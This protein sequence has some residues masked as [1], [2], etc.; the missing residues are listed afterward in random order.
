MIRSKYFITLLFLLFVFGSCVVSFGMLEYENLDNYDNDDDLINIKLDDP[1]GNVNSNKKIINLGTTSAKCMKNKF[2]YLIQSYSF[3]INKENYTRIDNDK[4][5]K[6]MNQPRNN[7][8]DNSSQKAGEVINNQEIKHY[9]KQVISKYEEKIS[10][11]NVAISKYEK[12]I[13]QLESNLLTGY[14]Q[15][16]EYQKQI[17]TYKEKHNNDLNKY[18][19]IIKENNSLIQAVEGGDPKVQLNDNDYITKIIS[20]YT[21]PNKNMTSFYT[22]F[23][24]RYNTS[25]GKMREQIEK[26]NGEKMKNMAE[27]N[28]KNLISLINKLNNFL[29]NLEILYSEY[30]DNTHELL[31][32]LMKYHMGIGTQLQNITDNFKLQYKEEP[33]PEVDVSIFNPYYKNKE[34]CS[35]NLHK[36]I[37]HNKK[38]ISH[39][40]NCK[41]SLK[42]I[43]T[44]DN[45]KEI[46]EEIWDNLYENKNTQN[47]DTIKASE[48]NYNMIKLV[49]LVIDNFEEISDNIL[50]KYNNDNN[51]IL[52]CI[53]NYLYDENRKENNNNNDNNPKNFYQF[54]YC[55]ANEGV[56]YQLNYHIV[57]KQDNKDGSSIIS[58][59]IAGM[60]SVPENNQ[61][62]S[63]AKNKAISYLNTITQIYK[64]IKNVEDLQFNPTDL[65]KTLFFN[66]DKNT[67]LDKI[68]DEYIWKSLS[69][70]TVEQ[71]ET[72]RSNTYYSP[73]KYVLVP[74]LVA[75][76]VAGIGGNNNTWKKILGSEKWYLYKSH[77]HLGIGVNYQIPITS[78]MFKDARINLHIIGLNGISF[79]CG[80]VCALLF[81][82]NTDYSTNFKG[83]NT[84]GKKTFGLLVCMKTAFLIFGMKDKHDYICFHSEY[85]DG[86][87]CYEH[88]GW[89]H[90]FGEYAATFFVNSVQFLSIDL[91]IWQYYS[92]S[93]NL[94][95]MLV[96]F[97]LGMIIKNPID[98]VYR[99]IENN[100]IVYRNI[101]DIDIDT[102]KN[103]K[104]NIHLVN[105]S[106]GGTNM[107][108]Q[109]KENDPPWGKTQITI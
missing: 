90:I 71:I 104:M 103:A 45:R 56:K 70:N 11:Y 76:I 101:A 59:F 8:E 100:D 47:N 10:N 30:Q 85:K 1:K 3:F 79:L 5:K 31:K 61:D 9:Y 15:I 84:I 105:N 21:T 92:I 98:S 40:N 29:N 39:H 109:Q 43:F 64:E 4:I 75:N 38:Q 69:K 80:V 62:F 16:K 82:S 19:S 52:Q 102:T 83:T 18:N 55:K 93:I 67:T 88:S 26:M 34:T 53:N 81:N 87:K 51:D 23:K 89:N 6:I 60:S 108:I 57:Q 77:L 22:T 72:I 32:L 97:M 7:N 106:D 14:N 33:I 49:E 17:N 68:I 91:N 27:E 107:E 37:I 42:G 54:L 86:N 73:I 20:Y 94:G 95:T 12:E 50:T 96:A 13:S 48:Y 35:W 28:S 99:D 44:K 78:G 2:R 58:M 36:D 24:T 41:Q 65:L 46:L 74:W 25:L 63:D 66:T